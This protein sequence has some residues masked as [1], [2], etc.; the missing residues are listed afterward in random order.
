MEHNYY[1]WKNQ[2][3]EKNPCGIKYNQMMLKALWKYRLIKMKFSFCEKVEQGN[4][5]EYDE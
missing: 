4:Y 2:E 3:E 5:Q 1:P